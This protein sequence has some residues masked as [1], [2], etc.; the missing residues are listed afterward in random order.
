MEG[1]AGSEG[2]LEKVG[3]RVGKRRGSGRILKDWDEAEEE[4][5]EREKMKRREKKEVARM[6]VMVVVRVLLS[7]PP[8]VVGV[9]GRGD[10]G[11]ICIV[12]DGSI[13]L[14]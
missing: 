7:L 9:V 13:F 3:W 1:G 8:G 11:G 2:N 5:D 12:G 14:A 6:T 10:G 4:E